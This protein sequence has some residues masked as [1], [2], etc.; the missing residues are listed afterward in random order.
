MPMP[1]PANHWTDACADRPRPDRRV[2]RRGCEGSADVPHVSMTVPSPRSP[3]PREIDWPDRST[4]SIE[5]IASPLSLARRD[6]APRAEAIAR[7]E[8]DVPLT[9]QFDTEDDLDLNRCRM[10]CV[11][12][13]G[14]CLPSAKCGKSWKRWDFRDHGGWGIILLDDALSEVNE[15]MSCV[16]MRN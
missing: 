2:H 14:S 4:S 16:H 9:P 7:G 8:V 11:R 12:L 5:R 15:Q 10:L 13:A 1:L 3:N 6:L